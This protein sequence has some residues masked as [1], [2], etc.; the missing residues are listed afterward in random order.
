MNVVIFVPIGLFLPSCFEKFEKNKP[1]F[2]T[3][4]ISSKSIEIVQG[5]ARIGMFELDDILGNVVG[6]EIGFGVYWGMKVLF[7]KCK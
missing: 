1:L 2:L 7:K 5:V 3:A 6:A 4:L